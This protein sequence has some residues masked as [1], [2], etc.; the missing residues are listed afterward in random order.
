LNQL[1]QLGVQIAIDDFGTGYN[2]LSYLTQFAVDYLKIDRSFVS[3]LPESEASAAVI[4][5]IADL[6]TRLGIKLVA[7]GVETDEQIEMLASLGSPRL[8][9]YRFAKPRPARDIE[10]HLAARA[11]LVEGSVREAENALAEP[12]T[13]QQTPAL[14]L[15]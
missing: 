3:Q 4:G 7:E 5:A 14:S 15:G 9:G 1:K 13:P 12:A 2:S 10:Y 6:A 8:Q 11:G